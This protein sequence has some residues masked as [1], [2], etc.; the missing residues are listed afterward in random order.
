[1]VASGAGVGETIAVAANSRLTIAAHALAWLEL[2]RRRGREVLTS[3]EVAASVNTNAVV[4]RRSL[5]DLHRAGL[6]KARRG[7]GAGFSLGRPAT[8]ITLLDVWLAVSPEPLLAL[9]HSEPNLQCPVGAGIRPV[10]TD[11]YDEATGSFQASLA[12]WTVDDVLE[13]ILS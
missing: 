4:V 2:A 13:R 11:V 7:N 10:L 6:V 8:G 5:S 9:H 1:V 12:R 3:D